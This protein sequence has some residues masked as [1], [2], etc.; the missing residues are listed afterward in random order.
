[1]IPNNACNDTIQLQTAHFYNQLSET[2][3]KVRKPWKAVFNSVIELIN[4]KST[5]ADMRQCVWH[6]AGLATY[7]GLEVLTIGRAD[8]AL[9]DMLDTSHMATH[10]ISSNHTHTMP[11]LAIRQVQDC[12]IEI[13]C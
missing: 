5:Y 2:K 3:L 4:A 6:V 13:Q 8:D 7:T 12:V 10:R 11:K 1:M 9:K